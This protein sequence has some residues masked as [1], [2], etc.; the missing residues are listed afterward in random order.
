MVYFSLFRYGCSWFGKFS[1]KDIV[2]MNRLYDCYSSLLTTKQKEYFE[3]Y[4]F[5][6]LTL[7]EISENNKVSRAAVH[8]NLKDLESKLYQFE[9]NLKLIEK[10]DNILKVVEKTSF[11]EEIKRII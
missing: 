11:Y 3:D 2:Y 10:F 9:T 8:K 5:N 4:Y 1:V 7:S 6:N